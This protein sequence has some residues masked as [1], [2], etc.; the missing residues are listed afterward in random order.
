M[1]QLPR[2]FPPVSIM[3]DSET[4]FRSYKMSTDG[5]IYDPENGKCLASI[6]S[7]GNVFDVTTEEKRLIG[8]MRDGNIYDLKENFVGHLGPAGNF[9]GGSTPKLFKNLINNADI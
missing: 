7:D 4:F 3:G 8:T 5:F 6:E 9:H 1:P 2:D